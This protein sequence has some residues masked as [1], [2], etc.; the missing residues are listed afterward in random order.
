MQTT[1]FEAT[2]ELLWLTASA[3]LTA[4]LWVPYIINRIR[5]NGAWAA[6]RNPNHDERPKAGWADRLMWAHTNGVEN[7]VVMAPL[8]LAAHVLNANGAATAVAAAVYF[9]ARVAH[10]IIYT[11]GVPLLRTL[12]FL[13]GFGAQV[14]FAIAIFGVA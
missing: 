6:L 9:F 5:E 14:T 11:A 4:S 7:L 2:P 10:A 1:H 12:A 13:G 8:V 3:L